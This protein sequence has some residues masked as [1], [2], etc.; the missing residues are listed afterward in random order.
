MSK[1]NKTIIAI[2]VP[3]LFFIISASLFYF[4]TAQ[5]KESFIQ[6]YNSKVKLEKGD[7]NL[8]DAQKEETKRA[9]FNI[10]AVE[11]SSLQ[12]LKISIS[13]KKE[14]WFI[15]SSTSVTLDGKRYQLLRQLNI[16][17][18]GIYDVS[19]YNS[20]KIKTNILIQNQS[21][22]NEFYK[23][24]LIYYAISILSILILLVVLIVLLVKSFRN[25][26]KVAAK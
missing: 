20:T 11:N 12:T 5:Y 26:K 23:S 2:A 3:I 17:K 9:H 13:P 25:N 14:T 15:G 6:L 4:T 8:Y 22:D 18:S 10:D 24:I 7:Y 16:S 21:A 19:I 1:R